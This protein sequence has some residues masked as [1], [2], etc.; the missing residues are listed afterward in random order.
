MYQNI[1]K[2]CK[3]ISEKLV[4]I[5]KGFGEDERKEDF[6][7][8]AKLKE[9]LCEVFFKRYFE[10]DAKQGPLILQPIQRGTNKIVDTMERWCMEANTSPSNV[11]GL[12]AHNF[13][14]SG[15]LQFFLYDKSDATSLYEGL[16]VKNCKYFRLVSEPIVIVFNPKD[17]VILFIRKSGEKILSE[18]ME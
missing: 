9:S 17:S 6:D 1:R 8:L 16:E 11:K 12:V 15:F 14:L 18:K 13:N 7:K 10:Q 4:K 5:K 2:H 3:V